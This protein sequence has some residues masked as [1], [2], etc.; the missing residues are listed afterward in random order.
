MNDGKSAI[1]TNVGVGTIQWT[2]TDHFGWNN[3]F[4]DDPWYENVGDA[5][6]WIGV[7]SDATALHTAYFGDNQSADLYTEH[8]PAYEGSGKDG[9]H[10]SL[11]WK[12][13]GQNGQISHGP[14]GGGATA[15]N[16]RPGTFWDPQNSFDPAKNKVIARIG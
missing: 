12:D 3:P 7:A 1:S 5:F 6:G 16:T 14:E 9:S 10:T 11:Q 13:G 2:G 8:G 15:T 4:D